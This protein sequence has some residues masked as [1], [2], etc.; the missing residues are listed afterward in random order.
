MDF[1]VASNYIPRSFCIT[2]NVVAF[3]VIRSDQRRSNILQVQFYDNNMGKIKSLDVGACEGSCMIRTVEADQFIIVN[4]E[5][6]VY[7]M[8]SEGGKETI[9]IEKDANCV[10]VINRHS[11]VFSESESELQLI[12]VKY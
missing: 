10:A 9:T 11:I 6:T 2:D 4:G 3:L 1:N 12:N 7:F 8:T 5:D